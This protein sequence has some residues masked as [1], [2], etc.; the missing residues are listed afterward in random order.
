MNH[1]MV[2]IEWAANRQVPD[3]AVAEWRPGHLQP[4]KSVRWKR[5]FVRTLS[6]GSPA[7]GR[8]LALS[9]GNFL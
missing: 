8:L 2:D 1:P 4:P 3:A 9:S 6:F 5:K 7:A